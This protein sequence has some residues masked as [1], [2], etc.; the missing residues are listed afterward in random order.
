MVDL[1]TS[2]QVAVIPNLNLMSQRTTMSGE[3]II[4]VLQFKAD[5]VGSYQLEN[6]STNLFRENDKLLIMPET[7]VKGLLLILGIIFFA[8]LF[9]GGLVLTFM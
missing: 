9:I 5:K 7:G 1:E 6:L 2:S 3:R 4:P 8:I